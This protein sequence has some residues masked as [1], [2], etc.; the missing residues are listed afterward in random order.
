L[1]DDKGSKQ[2]GL[3]FLESAAEKWH[4]D[5]QILLGELYLGSF[6]DAYNIQNED[7]I[8]V[9]RN[10]VPVDKKKGVSYFDKLAVSLY[11]ATGNYV[12]M[13][14]NLGI[15]FKAGVIGDPN[16]KEEARKWFSMSAERGNTHAMYELGMYYNGKGDYEKAR[17]WFT[18][19]FNAGEES[20]SAIMIGDYYFYGKGLAK[21][22][23]QSVQWYSK[24]LNTLKRSEAIYSEKLREHVTQNAT[25]RLKIAQKKQ[26]STPVTYS[27]A[28]GVRSYSVYTPDL[29]GKLIGA[30]H[31]VNGNI[32]ACVEEGIL[33]DSG[34]TD[35]TVA[36]MNEGLYWVLNAYATHTYGADKD[37]SFVL[38]RKRD[39][40]K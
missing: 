39:H 5:A 22:Y 24:A 27:L 11:S 26:Q 13:L 18:N 12:E 37:F 10:S 19:A 38:A 29:T 28:G 20:R 17:Q 14:H 33:P 4:V 16:N 1:K 6:P 15:L 2:R 30:V 8:A 36:S 34:S 31:N 21:D 9:L 40:L 23:D 3:R 25:H 35:K 7:K 32:Q